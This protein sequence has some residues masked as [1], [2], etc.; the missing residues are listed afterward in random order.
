[1]ESRIYINVFA[2]ATFFDG[3]NAIFAVCPIVSRKLM[4]SQPVGAVD[5]TKPP[6]EAN[7]LF[8]LIFNLL[9]AKLAPCKSI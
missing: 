3:A 2:L 4:T 9:T 8:P 6:T 1:L 5:G 7:L